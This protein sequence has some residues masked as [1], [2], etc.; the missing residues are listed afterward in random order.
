MALFDCREFEVRV[1]KNY[2]WTLMSCQRGGGRGRGGEFWALGYCV[3]GLAAAATNIAHSQ[4]PFCHHVTD[5]NSH[6]DW[7]MVLIKQLN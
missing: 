1:V 5:C 7:L 6:C 2:V 3:S 4:R